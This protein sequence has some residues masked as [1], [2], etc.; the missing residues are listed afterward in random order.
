MMI[1]YANILLVLFT[2][3]SLA[4][5]V[6]VAQSIN[7]VNYE[8]HFFYLD[9]ENQQYDFSE[10]EKYFFTTFPHNDPTQGDVIY[11]R[12]KW[13]N[14]DMIKLSEYNGL[15]GY[16]KNRND[17]L[18][19]DSF[20]FT[21]KPYYNLNDDV[22]KILFV[23]KGKFPSE[24]AVWPAWW[25]NGSRQ[26]EWLY[27]ESIQSLSDEFLDKYS[28]TG[29]FYNTP[30]PVNCTDWPAAGEVDIIETINGDNIIHNTI[31]TCPQMCD[32][33]WNDDGIIINCAN[34]T[35]TDPNSGCSGKSYK[36][37]SPEGT[38]ACLWENNSF[39]F[40]YWEPDYDV[41]LDGGPL[42]KSPRPEYWSESFLK[43]HVR[44]LE[45][46][47][48]CDEV[49]HKDWQCESCNDANK[50]EFANLKIIFNITL[51]GKWAG[52]EF[53]ESDNSLNNC[54][55]YILGEGKDAIDNQYFKIEY[56]SVSKLP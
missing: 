40:Y 7:S 3:Q 15:Y 46:S 26:D 14:D 24:K 48:Q 45:T 49:N 29:E 42:S 53:D 18:G 39:R 30:S 27:K 25:L 35:A 5:G 37:D 22:Q 16:I 9:F 10:V 19:F 11:D 12:V 4:G 50:C 54:K 52:D 8:N 51:C 41:R 36:V 33:E 20:R 28:G 23:F 32:S 13:V 31:H 1:N 21:S 6:C 38:F 17:S 2:I 55:D 44:F 47:I 56:V 43:N 34:A